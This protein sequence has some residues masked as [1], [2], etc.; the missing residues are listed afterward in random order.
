MVHRTLRQIVL[1]PLGYLSIDQHAIR[2]VRPFRDRRAVDI[3]PHPEP[4][5]LRR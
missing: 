3:Q 2:Q 4:V 1:T 5:G